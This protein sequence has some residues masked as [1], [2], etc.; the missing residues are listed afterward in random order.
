MSKKIIVSPSTH[1]CPLG[2]L[3]D[4]AKLL[5]A[6]GAD[7]L[8]CDIM[9]GKFVKDKTFDELALSLVAKR[10]NMTIDV[11]LMVQNPI[12][13]IQAYAAAGANNITVHYEALDGPIQI[14]EAINKIHE[15]GA[16]AG[17]SI[18]P[19]TPVS[20]I[21]SFLPFVDIVLVMSVEPG[22]S[23]QPF[24]PG[25][26]SKIAELHSIREKNDYKFLIEVDGGINRKNVSTVISL[27]A[28]AVVLGKAMYTADDKGDL[29]QYIKSLGN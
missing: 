2:D 19:A 20:S 23:G 4:Y 13:K 11:H 24:L 17:I 21:A 27:G 28:D 12:A 25:A 6:N 18:K 15:A 7:W 10:I 22:K 26:N 14:M 8:H 1:P 9:D 5:L 16:L 29:I 3:L